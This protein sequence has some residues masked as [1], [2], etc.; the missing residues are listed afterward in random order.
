MKTLESYYRFHAKIYDATRWSFL[1]GR[2]A[3]IRRAAEHIRPAR[4]LEVGCGTGRNM[5]QLL[6]AFPE[7]SVWGLDLSVDML[8]AARR[9]LSGM[10]DRAKLIHC[11]YDRPV[12]EDACGYGGFDL[13]LFAYSLS[14][15]NPGWSEA[16]DYAREDL[17]PG[18]MAAVVDFHD[19]PVP[20]FKSW[21]GVNH[22]RMDGHIPAKLR[23]TF[24]PRHDAVIRAYGG[25]WRYMMF[26]GERT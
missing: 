24:A 26:V 19:S 17:R 11:P 21:M 15:I 8:N 25:V 13:V 10:A 7:A 9:N 14:M 23:E 6:T 4:I 22:V 3:I 1:F 18:G 5:R 12:A 16:I 20:A 2:G